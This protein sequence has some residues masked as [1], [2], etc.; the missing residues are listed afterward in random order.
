MTTDNGE[1]VSPKRPHVY[2][3]LPPLSP[4]PSDKRAGEQ[5]AGGE[6]GRKLSG[7]KAPLFPQVNEDARYVI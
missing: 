5:G 6:G 3:P 1:V 4:N 7:A 2:P